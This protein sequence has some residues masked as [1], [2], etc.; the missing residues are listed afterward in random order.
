MDFMSDELCEF[1]KMHASTTVDHVA[2][3]SLAIEIRQRLR[4][5]EVVSFWNV[6]HATASFRKPFALTTVPSS[7]QNFRSAGMLQRRDT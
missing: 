6:L 3:E 1:R 5:N 4:R 2:R 7:N